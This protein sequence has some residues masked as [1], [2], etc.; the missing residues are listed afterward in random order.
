[1]NRQYRVIVV[2]DEPMI[3]RG[4]S[5]AVGAVGASSSWQ[6]LEWRGSIVANQQA[7]AP[8]RDYRHSHACHE[9]VGANEARHGGQAV[10]GCG[11]A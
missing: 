3:L 7:G 8:Y 5:L 11:V 2:D 1:M 6:S 10:D 9:R 4:L